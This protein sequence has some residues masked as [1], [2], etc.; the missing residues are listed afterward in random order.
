[1]AG[2]VTLNT[3]GFRHGQWPGGLFLQSRW[4]NTIN[5]LFHVLNPSI[6]PNYILSSGRK[7]R[8]AYTSHFAAAASPHNRNISPAHPAQRREKVWPT[9]KKRTLKMGEKTEK[10]KELHF[11]PLPQHTPPEIGLTLLRPDDHEE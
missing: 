5:F 6:H 10:K 1:M 9:E 3:T 11:P 4:R 8:K 7:S 2:S